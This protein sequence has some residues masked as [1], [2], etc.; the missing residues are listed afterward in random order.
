VDRVRT[1]QCSMQLTSERFR[2]DYS[3][4]HVR[5]QSFAIEQWQSALNQVQSRR[6]RLN[7]TKAVSRFNVAILGVFL[8]PV[9]QRMQNSTDHAI[10]NHEC[11][12]GEVFTP[13]ALESLSSLTGHQMKK[14]V[15]AA[16][17]PQ[18]CQICFFDAR[19]HK[20]DFFR[21]SWR[22]KNCLFFP[23]Y[24]AIFGGN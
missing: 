20:F 1:I 8:Y 14:R 18:G 19:F 7:P 16:S 4:S 9:F 12:Q 24:L 11:W 10:Q 15:Q 13:G 23:Q 6:G 3:S 2:H 21:N 22:Q 5:S 17:A